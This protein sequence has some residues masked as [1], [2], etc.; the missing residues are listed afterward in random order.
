MLAVLISVLFLAWHPVWYLV[1]K[2]GLDTCGLD[3]GLDLGAYGI[4]IGLWTC[5]L[6]LVGFGQRGF[7]NFFATLLC[8]RRLKK[9]NIPALGQT[10]LSR[11]ILGQTK[12]TP[13][14]LGRTKLP[15]RILIQTKFTQ[16]STRGQVLFHVQ[17]M[18]DRQ[19][20]TLLSTL[21][22]TT[23]YANKNRYRK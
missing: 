9:T 22:L 6:A 17:S 5:A 15:R 11:M 4:G 8:R 2:E 23:D 20:P 7:D 12:S 21:Q 3:F 18:T 19:I 10:K 16:T 1:C 13:I 14:T